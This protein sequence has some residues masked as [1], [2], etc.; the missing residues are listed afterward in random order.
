MPFDD[1]FTVLTT[2]APKLSEASAAEFL[3]NI[4]GVEGTLKLLVSERDQNFVV[5]QPSGREQVL[6]IA[7][8]AEADEV[9]DF[10]T[11]ALLHVEKTD[12][13]FPVPRV[14]PAINGEFRTTIA[15]DDGRSHT[16]RV[17]SWL[18]GIPLRHSES[19]PDNVEQ[20]GGLL[21]RLGQALKSFNHPASDYVLLWDMKQAGNLATLLHNIQDAS[22]QALCRRRLRRFITVVEPKLQELRSQ[23]IYNDLNPSN[24]LVD[25]YRP[26]SI[27]GIIDFGD[28]VRS[29]L[30]IDVA[31]GAA[32][33]CDYGDE[34]LTDVL[35]YLRGYNLV[36]PLQDEEVDL[37]YDLI[38]TRHVMT[39]VITNW[40]AA[41]YPENREY[42]LRNEP[43]ARKTIESLSNLK[44]TDITDLFREACND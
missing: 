37:L 24:V 12:P 36:T 29:P 21:A 18:D 40:R 27:T 10:Q 38:L 8:S 5:R 41:Q 23:V 14:I 3:R 19:K 28:M 39:I 1:A 15:G 26:E 42:I 4:Y 11:R 22:L 6:K 31:V 2:P 33:N 16:A 34:P 20:L 32:Y 17:L 35:K 44:I 13:A 9:S 25:P 43:R 7:N 30:D